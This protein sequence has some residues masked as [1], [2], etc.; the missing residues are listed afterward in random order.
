MNPSPY[1]FDLQLF[2]AKTHVRLDVKV[3][4]DAVT[5]A[6]LGARFRLTTDDL[7]LLP[8][9]SEGKANDGEI[10]DYL[11]TVLADPTG[12]FYCVETGQI[13]PGGSISVTGPSGAVTM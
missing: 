6:N 11:V 7:S 5:G 4:D 8:E 2:V 13:I 1:S 3:A 9:A 10:E 12:Y